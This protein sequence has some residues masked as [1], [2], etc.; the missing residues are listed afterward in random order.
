MS[1]YEKQRA[2][3]DVFLP[4][5]K[6]IL[7]E[8]FS[9]TGQIISEAPI[10]ED[11]E[12][13]TDIVVLHWD[14]VRI[15]CRVREFKYL[16]GY[17]NEFTI[18]CKV[19]SGGKTEFDK[20]REGWGNYFFYGFADATNTK[21]AKWILGDLNALRRH[22]EQ[23]KDPLKASKDNGD[24]SAFI[25]YKYDT[26]EGFVI[27]SDSNNERKKQMST[28]IVTTGGLKGYLTAHKNT[29]SEACAHGVSPDRLIKTACL[30]ATS[31]NGSAIAKCSPESVL[32]AVVD[33]A[34]FGIDPS[35]GR[36]Y[37]VPYGGEAELQLGYLG[38]IELAKRSGEIKSITAE[39][40]QEGDD[41]EVV[42]GTN[43]KF[44]HIPTFQGDSSTYKSVYALAMFAD[45]HFE[46][47]VLS[48]DDVENIRRKS[49][50]A[51]DSPAWKNY[52][53]EMAKKC[54]IRRLCKTLPLTIEALDAIEED[55]RRHSVIDVVPMPGKSAGAKADEVLGIKR[56]EQTA[57]RRKQ[58][59]EDVEP[60]GGLLDVE[61]EPGEVG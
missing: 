40:V 14:A 3:S 39:L 35:F 50:K 9:V 10:D 16:S 45:G 34:R 42:L 30:L 24:G 58:T 59:A 49:S 32:R 28:A 29:I 21:L 51:P 36:A 6:R 7:S 61:R 2:W 1:K 52:P 19:K 44:E 43:P 4:E 8:R 22:I 41:F 18:R 33:C 57:D 13:N 60:S 11:M 15:G 48:R 25:P 31:K 12:R 47:T 5:I 53:G 26:I 46:Y 27:D 17:G 55:D 54:A 56:G 23:Q 37:I 20:I 38:L